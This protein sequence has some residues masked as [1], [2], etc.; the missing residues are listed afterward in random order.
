[1]KIAYRTVLDTMLQTMIFRELFGFYG[2][3]KDARRVC[4][5]LYRLS[6]SSAALHIVPILFFMWDWVK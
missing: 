1:M 3:K 6:G 5:N 4:F 2:E